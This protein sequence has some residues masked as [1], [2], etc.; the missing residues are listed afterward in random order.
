MVPGAVTGGVT[1]VFPVPWAVPP[2]EFE[3]HLMVPPAHPEAFRVTGPVP[4]RSL[5]KATGGAIELTTT[6][7]CAGKPGQP[8]TV[9]K[10]S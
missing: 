7:T 5:N 2:F 6:S 3:Y 1:K 4:H 8:F 9:A 10:T